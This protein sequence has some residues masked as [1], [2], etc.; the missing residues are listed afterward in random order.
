MD[1]LIVEPLDPEVLDWLA[2][3]H[4][5]RY[6][7]ELADDPF[8]LRQALYATRAVIIPPSVALDSFSIQ[9][10]PMLRAVGRLSGGAENIDIEDCVRAGI[11]VVRPQDAGAAAEAEFVVGALL[12]LLRRVPVVNAEGLLVGRELGAATIGLLGITATARPL[13]RLL[14][15]FGARVIGMD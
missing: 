14:G 6:A 3:R 11:E 1:V 12:Q 13:A 9:S 7:P 15:A 5:V 4:S 8:R 10:A 2:A